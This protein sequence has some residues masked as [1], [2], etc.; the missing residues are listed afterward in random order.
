V[1]ARAPVVSGAWKASLVDLTAVRPVAYFTW[2]AQSFAERWTRR[3]GLAFSALV[4]PALYLSNKG[5]ATRVLHALLRGVTR[6]RLDLL[7]EEYFHYVLKAQLKPEG[8]SETEGVPRQQG[9]GD[10]GEQ[11]LDHVMRPLA[12]HVGVDRVLANR[13]E[14]RDGLATGR[15]LAPVI[16]RAALL[17]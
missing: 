14:F 11:G 5:F 2:N 9:A 17:P 6:D 15:L 8:S 7:G 16:R 1:P 12:Q 10:F 4:R 13:L 3:G